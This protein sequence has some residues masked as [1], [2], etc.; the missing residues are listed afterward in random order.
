MRNG[1][2]ISRFS[3]MKNHL[4]RVVARHLTFGLTLTALVAAIVLSSVLAGASF[5]RTK[6]TA[7]AE[8]N[9]RP[10][11]SYALNQ[12]DPVKLGHNGLASYASRERFEAERFVNNPPTPSFGATPT[13]NSLSRLR[14]TPNNNYG[15]DDSRAQQEGSRGN[16]QA[17]QTRGEQDKASRKP[18]EERLTRA[19]QFNG[20]LRDLPHRKPVKRERPELEGPEPNPTFYP[21][22]PP[23]S[24]TPQ[25]AAPSVRGLNV[26]TLA[27][28]APAPSIVFE[29][30]D[31][32]NWGAGSPPDT[33]GDVGPTYYIQSV[34]TSVGIF[35]KSDGFRE[36]AFTFDTLMS[37]GNFGNL[38]DTNN[39]GDPVVLY[40]TFEDRWILTDFAFLTDIN[41]NVLSPAYQCFAVSNNGNPVTGGWNF[42]SIKNSDF[43]NDYP[44]L[45]VWT[46]GLYMSA[47]MFSFGAG[48]TFQGVRV[49]SFNKAQMYA[50]S[51]T[52]KVITFNLGSGDFTIVPANA[53]LQTGTPPPGRPNL[54]LSTWNFANA[55]SVYKFH[56]DWNRIS[57]STFTGPDISIAATSWPSAN[58]ANAPQP[59]TATLLDVL[60]IRA[61]VQN[62]YSNFA[63]AESLWV[64]H[65]VRRANTAGFAAPRWYQV[66]I[67]GGTVAANLP[68]AAT[69][70]P[71]AANVIHRYMPSL[72]LDRAGNM[73]M[74]YTTSNSTTE[75]PSMRYA[76]RLSTDPINTFSQ[77]EQTLF[78]GT[79]SQ[80]GSSRWGDYSSM[81]LD[82]DGCTFWYTNEYANPADQTF[83]KRWLT[84]IG[85]FK[86]AA[87][88]PV[89]A[90]GTVSGTVTDSA[91]SNPISGAT[92]ALG[93]RTTTTNGSGVYIFSAIPAGTYASITA[94]FAGYGSSTATSIVVADAAT[95]TQDFSLIAAPSTACLTDTTQADFL[96]GVFTGV[97]LNTSPGDVT[98]L[99]LAID[100]QN[101]AGTTTGTGFGT[102]AWT[103]QTFIPTVNGQLVAA[104]IQVFCNGCG[105]TPPN[106]TLSVRDTAAGLPT[107]ADLASV[108]IPGSAFSSGATVTFTASFGSPATLTS[109]T[110]YAL[111]LRPVSV[112]AGSGYF[113]IR[114]SPSTYASGSR[115]LSANSGG[116]WSTDTTRDYNFKTY[117]RG[118][119]S[120]SGNLVS[121]TKDANPAPGLTPIWS[122]LSWNATTPASTSLKFQIAGS[123]SANG[124]FNFVGPDGTAATFFTTSPASLSQFYGLRY[125]QYNA[126][127]STTDSSVT[128]TLND[129]T[130]CVEDVD[131]SATA[132]AITLSPA[133]VCPNSTGNTASGPGG[134]TT[135][136]WSISNGTITSSTNEQSVTYTAGASGSVT[137]TL[138]VTTPSGCITPNSALVT[139]NPTPATPT[140]TP[141]G[142]TTFCA[143]G[144]VTLMSSSVSG[145]Q[146]FLNGNPIGGAT[147]QT[148]IATAAGDYTDVVTAN[149]CVSASSAATT[150]TVNP[151][152]ATPTITPDGP[153][154]FCTG[155]SVTLTSSSATG[156]Q[157]FLNGNP[158]GGATNQSYSA[159]A[160]GNYSV[161]ATTGSCTSAPSSNTAVTVNPIPATPTIT[162]DG[163]TT[164]CAGGSVTLSSNSATGIQWYL[165][166]NP[167]GGATNQNYIANATGS[168]T[169]TLNALG[170]V[171][172]ASD[173]ISI[174]VNRI[175]DT[176]TITPG[177][178]TT[179]CAGGSVT[180]TSNINSDG[181]SQWYL[182]GNPI[183]GATSSAYTA[184]ASG[185][186]TVTNTANGC[187]SAPSANT[188]VTVN[189]IPATPT[190]TPGGPTTFTIG[191]SVTLTSSS[192]S[193]NQWSLNGNP[194]GG[195]TNQSYIASVSG[196]YTVMVT[197][198]G[199][200]SAPSLATTV[201]VNPF[202]PPTINKLFLPDTVP[203]NGTTLLSFTISNPNSDPQPN[204]TL[205]GIAFTDNLPEGLV[206]AS[207][208]ELTND[209]GGTVTAIPGSSSISL[210][211]GTLAPA[212]Q[213]LRPVL[214]M[215]QALAISAQGT[216]F[217]SVK[218]QAPSVLGTLNNTTGPITSTESQPGTTSNTATLTVIA[219]PL[220]PTIAKA[221]DAAIIPLN[222]TTSL[223]FTF[224]NPN[225]NLTLMNVSANDTLPT[226]L[227][228][229]N[230]NNLIRTCGG[231]ISAN[232]GSTTLGITALTLPP[233]SSCS[234]SV[235]VK[236]TGA[237]TKN[238]TSE[239]VS[240]FY[241]DGTGNFVNI[242]GGVAT[243]TIQVQK[244][245]QTIT[246]G[247]LSDKTF[248]DADF[249]VSASASSGLAVSFTATGNCTVTGT[250]TVHLISAG[251]CT[252]TASQD[253]DSN[254]NA[255]TAVMQSFNIAQAAA[256]TSLSSSINPSDI[257]Q[258]VTFTATITS[259]NTSAPTGTVQ[260][261]DGVDN[262]GIAVNCVSGGGNTCTAQLSTSA[263][264]T[265]THAISA[266]YSGDT[267]F[268][269]S[270]GLLI[271]GQVVTSQP[272]LLLILDESNPA[273]N[274]AAA[275]D[276]LLLLRDPFP[277][278]SIASWWTFGPDRNTRAMVFVANLHLN[279][280]DD[281][282]VVVVNL[283]DS[284]N[285]SYDVP[286]EDVRINLVTGFAQVTFRLP[287]TL[288]IGACE[289]TVKAH[290]QISNSAFIS[291][292]P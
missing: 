78:T 39:F 62:Q 42:Y 69:W 79:A 2:S 199:C 88:T 235:N 190:I 207:A 94:S 238:N 146:W 125:L 182:N 209:C 220:P 72:A 176:P 35:R 140:I 226:G 200:N 204:L 111:I 76:G 166:G 150:V 124:P 257:G 135:Y 8:Q 109:G 172:A 212:A 108:T 80:T 33:N 117:M 58:V 278:Q 183:G 240:A 236:G 51:P 270:S 287:D 284:A 41:G 145:N 61:M 17:A 255:A 214:L 70:D 160:A 23:A 280:G 144:S 114:S 84:K 202:L 91:T 237:G 175:P 20:D 265:G 54:F 96:L 292:G 289:V 36:A 168:Y 281:N 28:Q 250:G 161:T 180:L 290:G 63:G 267:N 149:G 1:R 73:A 191:G 101:T 89:G 221:F 12:K 67:T 184:T 262:L 100:Q 156:N 215:T 132:P 30:L 264:T 131:C 74:G 230:P 251:S 103:G 279:P 19:H 153:T 143:G 24:V 55:L 179:F 197:T 115:V 31:R 163:P 231:D 258:S 211:G 142:P 152:P 216:C 18:K 118:P 106:L 241:E 268:I 185:D 9:Q 213:G 64:P 40:D 228:V 32:E 37:Q 93:S 242:V 248:G 56:V 259:A 157:W 47:N 116:T 205:T 223:T 138:T 273:P 169:A 52:V 27:V 34:N 95:T 253:G 130:V 6:N 252:I 147:N 112:P 141:D 162:P 90:G 239:N 11:T 171:S 3:H 81:M 291:I 218:V 285:Q 247:A 198:L 187:T 282:S 85:S 272:A 232:A 151:L 189:P 44:K 126:F 222:D 155:G 181:G 186:Y 110:Q 16:E 46:D 66:N 208:N 29:G 77:T 102:P 243:A 120:T 275:L 234:F 244:G 26:P 158:I 217:I 50:G 139:I 83:N 105:A 15:Q 286:A 122:T 21:G 210:V 104:D 256:V 165:D 49:W 225:S 164:F 167:I 188:A 53:R 119:Y 229:A 60:Q 277:V 224:T 193:G 194:I 269:G 261:K 195:A 260:F 38:C 148:Y 201:T 196:D 177:G 159:T 10:T 192:A 173:P 123:N 82:P 128:P 65:T 137:L 203:A 178:P 92:V 274:Q 68:Q 87:C 129:V 170:C 97:D 48:S 227:V 59:G 14:A 246:F 219:P 7:R 13:S 22:T 4:P 233:S 57:L 288:F 266:T 254:Y 107:G 113:W 136:A 5:Q 245:N 86:F 283:I 154:T 98:L 263:L 206:I 25:P 71:D 75:F 174:T 276:S 134:M 45:G 249:V 99:N 271:G 121:N 133:E 127:L 43:L